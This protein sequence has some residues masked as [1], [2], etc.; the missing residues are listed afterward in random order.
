MYKTESEARQCFCPFVHPTFIEGPP[1][2]GNPTC[3][4]SECM[5][6]RW[7]QSERLA[8]PDDDNEPLGHCGLAGKP[9]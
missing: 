6:W 4:A 9:D 1:F 3:I 2:N 5:A 7:D 8:F